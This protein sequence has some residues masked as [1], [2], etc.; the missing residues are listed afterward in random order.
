[1]IWGDVV[2]CDGHLFIFFNEVHTEIG[3]F[4]WCQWGG[5]VQRRVHTFFSRKLIK[6]MV[7]EGINIDVFGSQECTF[8]ACEGV[9]E[10]VWG[11]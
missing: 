9:L 5:L 4:V 11:I 3:V 10:N 2:V 8:E 7:V 6:Y 1:V